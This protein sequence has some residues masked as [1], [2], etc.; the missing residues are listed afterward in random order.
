MKRRSW[1]EWRRR[2][3]QLAAC[4]LVAALAAC[5]GDAGHDA[6]EGAGGHEER[7]VAYYRSPHDPNVT[8]PVPARDSMGMDFV[9]VYADELETAPGAAGAVAVAEPARRLAGIRTAVAEHRTLERS[10][11]TVGQV[12]PDETRVRHVHTKISGWIERLFVNYTGQAVRRGDPVLEIYSPQ[13][14]AG[15]EEFLRAR[16]AAE[17]FAQS[18]LPEVRRGGADLLAAARRRLEL[19]DVP[20]ALLAE[21]E[22][23]GVA[24]RTVVLSAPASGYVVSKLAVEGLEVQP[25][26]E[27]FTLIDLSRVWVEADLYEFEAGAVRVGQPATLVL[28]Y[29]DRQERAGRV[30]FIRPTLD[31]ATRTLKAR[32]EFANPDLALKPGMFA[33]VVLRVSLGE[34]VVVPDSAVLDSG[35]RKVVFVES[36]E[37]HFA[38]REVRVAG[39]AGGLVIVRE[40]LAAGERV[41]VSANFLL[42]SEARLRALLAGEPPASEPHRH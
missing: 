28:P 31:P 9:P 23:T 37:G 11:R 18:K 13:L 15:Q 41:A 3:R 19:L 30:T 35:V 26:M 22:R 12:L 2:R 14:L 42:D 1:R 25:G 7:R 38:P 34:G 29:G 8:S 33:D 6:E 36:E 21:L 10:V 39:E 4:A 32:L 40:G 16:E 24:R 20:E 27:L 5:G 17:R